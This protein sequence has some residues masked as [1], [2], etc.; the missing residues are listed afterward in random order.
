VREEISF[1]GALKAKEIEA[2]QMQ[3][4]EVVR[5]L[6]TDGEIELEEL[7]AGAH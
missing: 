4:I 6:E 2:A 5:Q 7:T 1:L 3:V